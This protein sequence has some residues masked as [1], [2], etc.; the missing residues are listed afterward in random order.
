MEYV[1]KNYQDFENQKAGQRRAVLKQ[2]KDVNMPFFTGNAGGNPTALFD[3][4]LSSNGG[5]QFLHQ[6]QKERP[7]PHLTALVAQMK[8]QADAEPDYYKRRWVSMVWAAGFTQSVLEK[9][10]GWR[11][12][13][14]RMF[15]GKVLSEFVL[16]AHF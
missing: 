1:K 3:A 10:F 9:E 15:N 4:F 12:G 5:R 16:L 7:Q 13:D 11:V 14:K 2:F 8:S 6:R